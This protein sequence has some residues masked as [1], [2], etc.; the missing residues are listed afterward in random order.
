MYGREEA[1]LETLV[2]DYICVYPG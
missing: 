1:I 2:L